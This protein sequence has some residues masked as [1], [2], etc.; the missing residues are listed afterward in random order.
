MPC[1]VAPVA[2]GDAAVEPLRVAAVAVA[3]EA[4]AALA[5]AYEAAEG[6]RR[7]AWHAA[8]GGHQPP[9]PALYPSPQE[10]IQLVTQAR[11]THLRFHS[12]PAKHIP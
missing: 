12:A 5:A 7:T 6:A 8:H 4:A 2:C 10:F 9:P 11:P 3:P 1:R